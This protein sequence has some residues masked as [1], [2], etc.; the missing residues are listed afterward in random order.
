MNVLSIIGRNKPL[1]HSDLISFEKTLISQIKDSKILV[2]GGAGSIGSEVVKLLLK[3]NPQALDVVDL[4]ENGLAELIRDIR[5]SENKTDT[6]LRLF[7][8]DIGSKIF[9]SFLQENNAYDYILNLSA[10]KHVRSE[11][12]IYTIL[13]MIEVNILNTKKLLDFSEKSKAKRFFSVS[14]DKAS[15]PANLMGAT[16][17]LMELIMLGYSE[18]ISVS[19][20]RFANV[21]FSN[22]SL[23]DSF[24]QRYNKKQPI[25]GPNDILRYFITCE[26]AAI[27]CV[28]SCFITPNRSIL[29]PNS[30]EVSLTSFYEIASR[31]LEEKGFYSYNCDSEIEA[32]ESFGILYKQNKWPVFFSKSNTSGEKSFEE[33][34]TK[35]EINTLNNDF[36]QEIS[37]INGSD[38]FG[39]EK[40]KIVIQELI[41][42]SESDNNLS[43]EKISHLF[44]SYLPEFAHLLNDK[45]LDEKM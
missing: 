4:S 7:P 16:K 20:A 34:Y 41:K 24:V 35:Q 17:R 26:E 19:S 31:F 23:L 2:T 5:S 45:N 22:G 6:I 37:I 32:K 14:T 43:K 12:D 44:S 42:L 15:N 40:I 11:K 29:I 30:L 1:F 39:L 8:L 18:N 21:A 33:F 10:I 25:S 38:L 27:L 36:F 13:R 28:L 9:D 3:Y